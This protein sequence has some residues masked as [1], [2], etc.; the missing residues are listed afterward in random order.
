MLWTGVAVTLSTRPLGVV[1]GRP[2]RNLRT[3]LRNRPAPGVL[4]ELF[5]LPDLGTNLPRLA[6]TADASE[7]PLLGPLYPLLIPSGL[8]FPLGESF[9]RKQSRFIC[10]FFEQFQHVS[11][12][13]FCMADTASLEGLLEI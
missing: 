8:L 5:E 2:P 6:L 1:F 12:D 10:P 4:L 11:S 3:G 9:K 7:G 13:L